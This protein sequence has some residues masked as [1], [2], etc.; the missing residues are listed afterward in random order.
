MKIETITVGPFESNC[1]IVSNSASEAL[2]IDPGDNADLVIDR[3]KA[4]QFSV[5]AIL[6]TH[7]HIDHVSAL[8]DVH[9]AF[10]S[11]VAMHPLDASWA[12]QSLNQ[13]M[14]YYAPPRAPSEISRKLA[15]GQSWTDAGFQ[16]EIIETPGH[17]P[18]SVSFYFR[19]ENTLFSGDALFNGSVGRVDL[20][21]GD[22]HVL[23]N[24]LQRL[25]ELPEDTR[26]YPGH[27]P[28]TTIGH[29]KNSNPFMIHGMV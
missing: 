24:T 21:G 9:R 5:C 15:D 7:G 12:F 20:P 10:P 1:Y 25:A 18:G 23:N 4:G 29:E 19:E 28:S 11:P 3:V 22:A 14:P 27:G 6:I 16:Y 13:M 8:A 17:S 26:V 2:I